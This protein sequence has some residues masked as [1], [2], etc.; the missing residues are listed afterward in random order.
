[1]AMYAFVVNCISFINLYA[2]PIALKNIT[3]NYIFIFVGWD[4]I[5]STLWYFLCV[6]TV[7]RTLEELDE[8]FSAKNPVAASKSK[9]QVAVKEDGAVAVVDQTY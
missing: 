6:E 9:K 4:L 2:G 7:G 8:I 5:E 3:H 1:M